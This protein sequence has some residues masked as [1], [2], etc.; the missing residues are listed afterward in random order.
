MK[1]VD[2]SEPPSVWVLDFGDVEIKVCVDQWE[3]VFRNRRSSIYFWTYLISIASDQVV[4]MFDVGEGFVLKV[5][6]HAIL[7]SYMIGITYYRN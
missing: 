5:V 7:V 4:V 1:L 2:S 3:P 6:I